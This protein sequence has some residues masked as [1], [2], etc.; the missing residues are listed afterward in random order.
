[1]LLFR[2]YYALYSPIVLV[3]RQAHR[4]ASFQTAV[5]RA[6]MRPAVMGSFAR[7]V[8]TMHDKG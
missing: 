2:W 5:E 8:V 6:D 7:R 1:M 3:I 4:V